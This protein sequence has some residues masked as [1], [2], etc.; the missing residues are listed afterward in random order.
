MNA[1]QRCRRTV[2]WRGS[3]SVILGFALLS[4]AL[5]LADRTAPAT[6]LEFDGVNLS[7]QVGHSQELGRQT[8]APILTAS[9]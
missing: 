3:F 6:D 2:F 9:Q 1:H 5:M 7:L 8:I 4:L